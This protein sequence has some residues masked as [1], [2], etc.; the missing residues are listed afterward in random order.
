LT[1]GDG[2]NAPAV[3]PNSDVFAGT[4]GNGVFRPT[5]NGANWISVNAGLPVSLVL[6]VTG[7]AFFAGTNFGGGVLI[8]G[9]S[10]TGSDKNDRINSDRRQSHSYQC[11]QQVIRWHVRHRNGSVDRRRPAVGK[12]EQ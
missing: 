3:L 11:E 8:D 1:T 9:Q 12:D 4:Y 10:N 6:S 2:V 7:N 5:D